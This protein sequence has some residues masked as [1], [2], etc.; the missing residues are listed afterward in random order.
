MSEPE[1]KPQPMTFPKF[2]DKCPCCGSKRRLVNGV[3]DEQKTKGFASQK[4]KG[5]LFALKSPVVDPSRI[6]LTI[7]VLLPLIDACYDC[8]ALYVVEVNKAIG[9]AEMM[10]RPGD[11]IKGHGGL[12]TGQG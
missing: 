8:G 1:K 3:L 4:M 12:F 7:P 2:Y 11:N 9:H 10:Q 6:A 5:V